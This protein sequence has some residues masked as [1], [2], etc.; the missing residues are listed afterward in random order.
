MIGGFSRQYLAM[1]SGRLAYL[2][3][4][5]AGRPRLLM[6]HGVNTRADYFDEFLPCIAAQYDIFAPD[7]RGHGESF[8]TD[9]PYS[10][11]NYARDIEWLIGQVIG[12]RFFLLGM[13][14]G[15]RV[16]LMLA[17]KF[18]ARVDKLVVVDVGPDVDP[19][20]LARIIDAQ[21]K[22]P[23]AFASRAD[24]V[25][26]YASAY[27]SVSPHYVER[28]IR[29]GWRADATGK[30]TRSYDRRV[31][32]LDPDSFVTDAAMLNALLPQVTMPVLVIRG[33]LSDILRADAA[34]DFVRRL[35]DGRLIEIPDTTHGVIVEAPKDCAA[36]IEA[37]F[38]DEDRATLT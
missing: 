24:L 28:I 25:A 18:A 9:E 23:A 35:P 5:N 26:F 7:F 2:A 4:G 14:L 15:G 33:G 8:H 13:S 32:E 34:A 22:L 10:L 30:M 11:T 3:N 38:A 29:H 12:G 27:A 19:A 16:G 6:L 20:G 17:A 31:W 1:P 37:F 21:A 36:V